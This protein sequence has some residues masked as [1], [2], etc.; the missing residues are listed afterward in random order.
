ME[1]ST[2]TPSLALSE[3]TLKGL[4]DQVNIKE[5]VHKISNQPPEFMTEQHA[6]YFIPEIKDQARNMAVGPQG[7]KIKKELQAGNVELAS[8]RASMKAQKKLM[9]KIQAQNQEVTRQIIIISPKGKVSNQ[10]FTLSALMNPG[11]TI[12]RSPQVVQLPCSRLALGPLNGKNLSLWYD[13]KKTYRNKRANK[14]F[15]DI[16]NIV[17]EVLIIMDEGDLLLRDF[18]VAEKSL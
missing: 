2:S 17:G 4:V 10:S 6:Q 1:P 13:E 7:E 12:L 8:L 5:I 9:N 14:I 15:D 11:E 16:A 18:L 3:E